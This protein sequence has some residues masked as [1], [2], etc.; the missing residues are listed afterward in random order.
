MS[1]ERGVA[2][3]LL[4][5]SKVVTAYLEQRSALLKAEQQAFA[6]ICKGHRK[7]GLRGSFGRG[8][9]PGSGDDHQMAADELLAALKGARAVGED[10]S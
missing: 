9:T 2:A 3:A 4:A 5:T 10:T 6:A 8:P 7:E 1:V